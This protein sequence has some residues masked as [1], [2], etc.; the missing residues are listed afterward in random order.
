MVGFISAYSPHAEKT[1]VDAIQQVFPGI[2]TVNGAHGTISMRQ[3]QQAKGAA[4]AIG[5]VVLAYTGLGWVS[6]LRSSLQVTF[7]VPQSEK[8][9]FFLGKAR[10]SVVMVILGVVMLVSVGITGVVQQLAGRLVS[11]VG[12]GSTGVGG[13][14]VWAV[15]ILLAL[16]ASV[17]LFFVMYRVLGRPN[18]PASVLWRGALL[19]AVGF[20]V[21]KLLVVYV[22]GRVGGSAFAPLAIAITLMVW[23]NYFSRLVIYGAAWARTSGEALAPAQARRTDT[24]EAAV[25]VADAADAKARVPVPARGPT[26]TGASGDPAPRS[27]FDTGSALLGAVFGALT[28]FFLRRRSD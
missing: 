3:I 8:P 4:G 9:N 26:T 7:E 21:L 11:A 1:R 27:R 18:L 13:P 12:L 16:L 10:D 15:G 28:A 24:S 25:T 20:E 19:A 14:L 2:V 5:L 17:L 23:I 6:G 22:L